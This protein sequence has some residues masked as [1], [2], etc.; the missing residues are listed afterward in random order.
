MVYHGF[1]VVRNGSRPSTVVQELG[2]D[3]AGPR[4]C[5]GG[6]G[7][8]S[9][10]ERLAAAAAG[11]VCAKMA[12]DA[13]SMIPG[14]DLDTFYILPDTQREANNRIHILQLGLS[15]TMIIFGYVLWSWGLFLGGFYRKPR[16]TQS[17]VFFLG[18]AGGKK[19]TDPYLRW[20][21]SKCENMGLDYMVL[22][23][24]N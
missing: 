5:P 23:L 4:E 11:R 8:V 16:G 12:F 15:R 10:P 20:W 7:A 13:S 21:S 19:K 18:G 14:V 1:Q 22:V 2:S 6:G 9:L 17:F 3:T 24:P